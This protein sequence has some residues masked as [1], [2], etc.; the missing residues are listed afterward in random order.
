M[1]LS[2]RLD[3]DGSDPV[4]APAI[5]VPLPPPEVMDP[6]TLPNITQPM[7]APQ[8]PPEQLLKPAPVAL[9]IDMAR[10]M[11]LYKLHLDAVDITDF[12]A[13]NTMAAMPPIPSLP[14]DTNDP[15]RVFL[16]LS[17]QRR[18]S[19]FHVDG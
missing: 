6:K 7:E 12:N 4:E 9:G 2:P 16:G 19:R 13:S 1:D 11:P 17:S 8:E 5:P 14:G 15:Y 10:T 18:V 3:L